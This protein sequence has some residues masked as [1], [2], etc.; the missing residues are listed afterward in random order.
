MYIKVM[1]IKR[2]TNVMTVSQIDFSNIQEEVWNRFENVREDI[3]NLI[4]DENVTSKIAK[5]VMQRAYVTYGAISSQSTDE[6]GNTIRSRWADQ[7]TDV[8]MKHS[9]YM[10]DMTE[11]KFYANIETDPRDSKDADE[12]VALVSVADPNLKRRKTM[13][14]DAKT[15]VTQMSPAADQ[16]VKK[17][18]AL[19][20]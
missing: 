8:A 11:G 3:Y 2:Q 19:A 13:L 18:V 4:M 12:K 9:T 17:M 10:R 15:H 16:Y 14:S 6:N 5:K 7:V 1:E 20:K